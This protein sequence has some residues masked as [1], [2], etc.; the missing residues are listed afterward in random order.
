[1]ARTAG[2]GSSLS[3]GSFVAYT[4]S[5]TPLCYIIRLERRLHMPL[6]LPRL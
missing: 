2:N 1:M 4:I 3:G 6:G 5:L